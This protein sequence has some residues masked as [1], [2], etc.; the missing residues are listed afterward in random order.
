MNPDPRHYYL[1]AAYV[2]TWA[3]H[4]TYLFILSRKAARIRR[5]MGEL[6]SS[7]QRSVGSGQRRS[8]RL[9]VAMDTAT[10]T[11]TISTTSTK[12][13]Q[14]HY[15]TEKEKH[16]DLSRTPCVIVAI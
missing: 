14:A 7:G 10:V 5:E 12:Q 11:V 15:Y 3:I 16:R 13:A 6:R 1:F 4:G 8:S 9:V 2:V